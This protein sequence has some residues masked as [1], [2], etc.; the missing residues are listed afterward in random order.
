MVKILIGCYKILLKKTCQSP[1]LTRRLDI[2]HIDTQNNG[3]EDNG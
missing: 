3:T 2:R 1:W